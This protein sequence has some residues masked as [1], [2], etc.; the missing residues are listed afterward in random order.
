MDIVRITTPADIA[1][2][3]QKA[4]EVL[5]N[6]GIILY[7]TDT[8]Y[9]LG[10]DAT[11]DSVVEKIYKIKGRG[12]GYSFLSLVADI[13][14][15]Q[16][17]AELNEPATKLAEKFLPGPL[18]LILK[19]KEGFDTGVGKDIGTVGIRIPDNSFCQELARVFG[20]AVVT[21]SANKNGIPPESTVEKILEQLG[22]QAKQIDLCIDAGEAVGTLPSTIVDSTSGVIKILREGA[23]SAQKIQEIF[24]R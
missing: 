18:A 16:N 17:Y 20:G 9:G 8:V 3:A 5:K 1:A 7:P 10:G 19:K 21:T 15:S 23:I 14:T 13:Q 4:A 6:G 22:E 12:R 11:L 24:G 2:A